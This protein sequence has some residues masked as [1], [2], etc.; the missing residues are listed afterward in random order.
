[1]AQSEPK[2]DSREFEVANPDQYASAWGG[3]ARA[4]LTEIAFRLWDASRSNRGR[5]LHWNAEN[6]LVYLIADLV[7]VSGGR[8]A[9]G[10]QPA[11]SAQFDSS[12]RALVCAKR[13][14]QSLEEF[15]A[16]RPGEPIGAAVFIYKPRS[17]ELTGYSSELVQLA[18]EKAKPGQILLAENVWDRLRDLPGADFRLIA[19]STG[20]GQSELTELMWT[21]A[22]RLA[23]LRDS[24]GD[25]MEPPVDA[26]KNLDQPLPAG[27]TLIVHSPVSRREPLNEVAPPAG[28]GKLVIKE[29]SGA[30]SQRAGQIPNITQ[31]RAPAFER[32]QESPSSA[33][34]DGLD[35]FAEQPLFTRNRILLGAAGLVLV[36]A[37]VTVLFRPSHVVK[38]PVVPQPDQTVGAESP[39][40]PPVVA[41]VA[42]DKPMLSAP[43]TADPVA[44]TPVVATQPQKP[45]RPVVDTRVK[46]KKVADEE[47]AP[48]PS[49]VGG[50]SQKDIPY[51]LTTAQADFGAGRYDDARRKF[52]KVLT[53]QPG[54]QD[55]KEG[56]RRLEYIPTDQR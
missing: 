22:E 30:G 53:L 9:E 21:T 49:E 39:A 42:V 16:C 15:V 18:L 47:P 55:A 19:A 36:A 12:G 2:T 17:S 3:D 11:M 7:G 4:D 41:P 13:I 35:E 27:A 43:A 6:A 32:F 45:S 25:D 54:N 48:P 26:A 50:L 28:M 44:K 31:D 40:T 34:T 10:G 5:P 8:V 20:D 51:L 37:L 56:L 24:V 23:V 46:N 52:R 14:Q 29:V 1:M 33:F 38:A